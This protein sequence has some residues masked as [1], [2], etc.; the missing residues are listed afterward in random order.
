[1]SCVWWISIIFSSISGV[2][3]RRRFNSDT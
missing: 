1:L 2:C 3:F